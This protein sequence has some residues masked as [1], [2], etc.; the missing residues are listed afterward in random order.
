MYA[1]GVDFSFAGLVRGI[2]DSIEEM[3]SLQS[4]TLSLTSMLGA[5]GLQTEVANEFINRFTEDGMVSLQSAMTQYKNLALRGFDSSQIERLMTIAKDFAVVNRKSGVTLESALE[6]LTE[7]IKLDMS[8]LMDASG[9]SKNLSKIY[10]DYANKIGVYVSKLTEEQK[11]L[12]ILDYFEEMNKYSE[13]N[14]AKMAN[15]FVGTVS[16][17]KVQLRYLFAE[18]GRT[19]GWVLK[20]VLEE[21]IQL[22][23]KWR[24]LVEKLNEDINNFV[25]NFNS[26]LSAM[27]GITNEDMEIIRGAKNQLEGIQDITSDKSMSAGVNDLTDNLEE[28]GNAAEKLLAPFDTISQL[29]FK[30]T[31]SEG[32]EEELEGLKEATIEK[33]AKQNIYWLDYLK[34]AIKNYVKSLGLDFSNLKDSFESLLNTL[35]LG[36]ISKV[37]ENFLLSDEVKEALNFLV[38]E[39]LPRIVITIDEVVKSFKKAF[40]GED[41]SELKTAFSDFWDVFWGEDG[42]KFT[43]RVVMITEDYVIPFTKWFLTWALPKILILLKELT[44]FA[45]KNGPIISEVIQDIW[46]EIEPFVTWVFDKII[47]WLRE[48]NELSEEERKQLI[49]KAA[50]WALLG[51]AMLIFLPILFKVIGGVGKLIKFFK[52]T[53]VATICIGWIK[54]I[55][56]WF[57]TKAI[58]WISTTALPKLTSVI[59]TG[60]NTLG[61]RILGIIAGFL[62]GEKMGEHLG[63]W[64]LSWGEAGEIILKLYYDLT[65]DFYEPMET[66]F[67][68]VKE[69]INEIIEAFKGMQEYRD[70]LHEKGKITP[71]DEMNFHN[72]SAVPTYKLFY[73]V[74][75]NRE[76]KYATG[77]SIPKNS[78]QYDLSRSQ[79]R[80]DIANE[81][82]AFKDSMRSRESQVS[83]NSGTVIH[84]VLKLDG[85]VLYNSNNTI[86]RQRGTLMINR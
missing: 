11:R 84:N 46:K 53:G 22:F 7:G 79:F 25:F 33:E 86:S 14:A 51:A 58:P 69:E 60:L 39:F 83:S 62:L 43:D 66:F 67:N 12:A 76:P 23:T 52:D 20:P 3:S 35:G 85:Q 70:K 30:D 4:A 5:L 81:I 48:F 82:A 74:N 54:K 10:S 24:V 50:K 47:E 8:R 16:R 63:N 41:F 65:K 77:T 40:K 26:K 38:S 2:K 61:G 72:F 45:D 1:L 80:T 15:T 44:E 42:E 18:I 57:S 64:I 31:T 27:F 19:I 78:E 75:N 32:I 49:E 29:K 21:I 59:T 9:L 36:D 71:V 13:G 55:G 17:L 56:T 37:F 68:W 28:A 73:D 34:L 6:N